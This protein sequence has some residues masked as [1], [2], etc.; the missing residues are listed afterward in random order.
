MG[1]TDPAGQEE[2]CPPETLG[3]RIRP[4]KG[5]N[6]AYCA[7]YCMLRKTHLNY[8]GGMRPGKLLGST[9]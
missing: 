3:E 9:P 1:L 2:C 8:M 6:S 4:P 5:L 7:N